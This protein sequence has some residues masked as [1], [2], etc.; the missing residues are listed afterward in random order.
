LLRCGF[1]VLF[2]N[3]DKLRLARYPLSIERQ[4]HRSFQFT[5]SPPTG[6]PGTARFLVRDH[7]ADV[8]V[9]LATPCESASDLHLSVQNHSF[10]PRM[11]AKILKEAPDL[12]SIAG[13]F[14]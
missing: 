11:V 3:T 8:V 1:G 6:L 14:V 2:Q 13:D 4:Q 10:L 9:T 12:I 7:A 5:N